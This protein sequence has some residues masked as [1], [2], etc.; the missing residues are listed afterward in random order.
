MPMKSYDT[1]IKYKPEIR[2]TTRID[3][4]I[5]TPDADYRTDM[6][7]MENVLHNISR[8][9][10]PTHIYLEAYGPHAACDAY[11]EITGNTEKAVR[12]HADKIVR[13]I[14]RFKHHTLHQNIIRRKQHTLKV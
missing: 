8:M 5:R 7:R 11:V 2:Y 3:F 12:K 13:Y 10:S 1:V 4:R 9:A 6:D 14:R